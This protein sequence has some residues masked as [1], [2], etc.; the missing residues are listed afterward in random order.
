VFGFV[1]CKKAS[2]NPF[3][4]LPSKGQKQLLRH[5]IDEPVVLPANYMAFESYC[6]F[7][8]EQGHLVVDLPF[9]Y[10]KTPYL[11]KTVIFRRSDIQKL[12]LNPS[13]ITRFR[14]QS[15]HEVIEVNK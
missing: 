15:K 10:P 14:Q 13:L 5:P 4:K 9:F 12:E 8:G 6:P 1:S 7:E 3:E 2:S 11:A